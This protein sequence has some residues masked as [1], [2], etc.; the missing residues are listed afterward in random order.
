M[1]YKEAIKWLSDND[2]CDWCDPAEP[3]AALSVTASFVAD[4][5]RKDDEIIRKDLSKLMAREDSERLRKRAA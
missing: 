3:E 5:F 4:C 2:D 1:T